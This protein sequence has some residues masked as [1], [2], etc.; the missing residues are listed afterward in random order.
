[1]NKN[2]LTVLSL[3][4]SSFEEATGEYIAIGFSWYLELL[5]LYPDTNKGDLLENWLKQ[6]MK[7]V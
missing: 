7:V 1:M 2:S 3:A 5:R 4:K 6:F